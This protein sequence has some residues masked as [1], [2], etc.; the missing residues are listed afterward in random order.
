MSLRDKQKRFIDE[1]MIDLNATQAALR[2]GYS[3]QW[4]AGAGYRNMNKPR[5]RE[6]IDALMRQ[7]S[8]KMRISQ[9]N[10]LKELAAI[11]FSSPKAVTAWGPEGIRVRDSDAL[12]DAEAALVAEIVA[13][14]GRT[15]KIKL[16]DRLKALELLGRHLGMFRDRMEVSGFPGIAE[17]LEAAAQRLREEESAGPLSDGD[18]NGEGP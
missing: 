1:Y 15:V 4:A 3:R 6:R 18:E 10:V 11:A 7:R 9:E 8:E 5:I 17:R 14:Q 2:A 13:P 16:Y 12:A